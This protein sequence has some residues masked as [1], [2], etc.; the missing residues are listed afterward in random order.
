VTNKILMVFA[1]EECVSKALVDISRGDNKALAV[2]APAPNT[3]V[4]QTIEMT[5][6]FLLDS[7]RVKRDVQVDV[8]KRSRRSVRKT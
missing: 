3:K 8:T 6:E 2:I 7:L 5:V 4:G 1:S